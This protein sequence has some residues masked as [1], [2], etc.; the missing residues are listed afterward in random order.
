[1]FPSSAILLEGSGNISKTRDYVDAVEY[2][3]SEAATWRTK[4]YMK[5]SLSILARSSG[6]P[7]GTARG[8]AWRHAQSL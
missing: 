2:C 6:T 4:P 3:R 7:G 8:H 1:M 5:A